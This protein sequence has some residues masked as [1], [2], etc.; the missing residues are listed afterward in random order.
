MSKEVTALN[1]FCRRLTRLALVAAA[2]L[3]L[4]ALAGPESFLEQFRPS[5]TR[6][7]LRCG[8]TLAASVPNPLNASLDC[9]AGRLGFSVGG[10]MFSQRLDIKNQDAKVWIDAGNLEVRLRWH[11]LGSVFFVG[12]A[13]GYQSL[14]LRAQKDVEIDY[15]LWTETATAKVEL[16]TRR[17]YA[18]P[19]VGWGF[20]FA[21]HV[22]VGL[23]LGLLVP[24]DPRTSAG[25][26]VDGEGLSGMGLDFL[27]L[28]GLADLGEDELKKLGGYA[29]PYAS[30]RVGWT[31]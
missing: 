9:D 11:P 8:V 4:P 18:M 14:S 5:R 20:T 1:R 30:L 19:H 10:G 31:F 3:H 25:I 16:V 13:L 22:A 24:I 7:P 2:M 6:T 28:F 27:S 29:L 15:E 26:D 17:P 21:K 12:G 23:E